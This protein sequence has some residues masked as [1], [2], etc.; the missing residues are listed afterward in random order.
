MSSP[1]PSGT[2]SLSVPR[3]VSESVS[4]SIPKAVSVTSGRVTRSRTN[5][6]ASHVGQHAID[7]SSR[8][9]RRGR[10][11]GRRSTVRASPAGQRRGSTHRMGTDSSA[12]T[13]TPQRRHQRRTRATAR[14]RP[15]ARSRRDGPL[16]RGV[17]GIE[18]RAGVDRVVRRPAGEHV[19][20]RF[21]RR[22]R[23][24]RRALT[25]DQ[26]SVGGRPSRKR[27]AIRRSLRGAVRWSVRWSVHPLAVDVPGARRR[28]RR[29][30]RTLSSTVSERPGRRRDHR[31]RAELE[32]GEAR[33]AV[34]VDDR[35]RDVCVVGEPGGEPV[36]LS[37]RSRAATR[38]RGASTLFVA[39]MASRD[40]R[41]Y[42]RTGG[43]SDRSNPS[44][45]LDMA[46]LRGDSAVSP[47]SSPVRSA[48]VRPCG[49]AP[50]IGRRRR[51]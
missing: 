10:Y 5:S 18:P 43:R 39:S 41:R 29:P 38:S 22:R 15:A 49:S 42:R 4:K 21:R 23:R 24:E 13:A 28:R 17:K 46:L 33:E 51:A 40:Q 12:G 27:A 47:E 20:D 3:A 11:R 14:D 44:R 2:V 9:H 25:P 7:R 1:S 19:D 30:P 26:Q 37:S 31:E 45:S 16:S 6:G 8:C 32:H 35:T 36:L 48:R 34:G 50:T